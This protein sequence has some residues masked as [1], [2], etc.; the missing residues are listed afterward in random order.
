M[1][2]LLAG[3]PGIVQIRRRPQSEV[4]EYLITILCHLEAARFLIRYDIAAK[5]RGN[6]LSVEWQMIVHGGSEEASHLVSFLLHRG[7][8][9]LSPPG[10]LRFHEKRI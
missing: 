8:I 4:R 3:A 1:H 10:F 9:A 6:L 5:Q 2:P 7:L